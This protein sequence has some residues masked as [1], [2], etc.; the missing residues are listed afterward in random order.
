MRLIR[1]R[2]FSYWRNLVLFGLGVLLLKW[3]SGYA[4]SHGIGAFR[5]IVHPA[6][7]Q[8]LRFIEHSRLPVEKVFES[9]VWNITIKLEPYFGP[10]V[11]HTAS[12]TVRDCQP[13]DAPP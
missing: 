11:G 1:R 4:R 9:G 2:P 13:Q 12:P 8:V 6:N 7:T 10:Q 3:L 5:A